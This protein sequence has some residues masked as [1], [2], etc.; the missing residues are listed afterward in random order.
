VGSI[1]KALVVA[2]IALAVVGALLVAGERLGFRGLPGDIVWRGK[3]STFYFPIVTC[4]VVSV[5][6]TLVLRFF[7]RR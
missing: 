3:S 6:L 7:G 2:G 1:G 5:V 4:L